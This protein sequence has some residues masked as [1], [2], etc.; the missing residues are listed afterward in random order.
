M[1]ILYGILKAYRQNGNGFSCS[2]SIVAVMV[3]QKIA[4]T[5]KFNPHVVLFVLFDGQIVICIYNR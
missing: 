2:W 5:G 3:I 1:D 4:T